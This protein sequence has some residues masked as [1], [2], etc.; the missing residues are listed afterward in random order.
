MYFYK[1]SPETFMDRVNINYSNCPGS[2]TKMTAMLMYS[3]K[4]SENLIL[5]EGKKE[6]IELCIKHHGLDLY[7]I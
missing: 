1:F 3:K 5:Q 4:P 2:L 7:L 6:I